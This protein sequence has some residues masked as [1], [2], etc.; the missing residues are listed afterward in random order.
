MR[1]HLEAET[2]HMGLIPQKEYNFNAA[3]DQN[4]ILWSLSD[5]PS[6]VLGLQTLAVTYTWQMELG[7]LQ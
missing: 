7:Y 6:R 2:K 5:F 3:A 1:E 4:S